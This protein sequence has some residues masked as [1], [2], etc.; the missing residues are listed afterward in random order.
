MKIKYAVISFFALLLILGVLSFMPHEMGMGDDTKIS[1]RDILPDAEVVKP[2]DVNKENIDV[3]PVAIDVNNKFPTSKEWAEYQKFHDYDVVLDG[4]SK[5]GYSAYSEVQ[6]IELANSGD[7]LAMKV[8][9]KRYNDMA[10][11][12]DASRAQFVNSETDNAI[13]F[14]VKEYT[15]KFN[16][17]VDKAILHGDRE[18]LT[19]MPNARPSLGLSS[20]NSEEAKEALLETMAVSE[21]WGMRGML[22]KKYE[23]LSSLLSIY[24]QRQGEKSI[25]LTP[26]INQQVKVRAQ[27]IYNSYEERRIALGLG[28][29]DNSLPQGKEQ[30]VQWWSAE[31][32]KRTEAE[33]GY[34]LP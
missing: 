4:E 25:K 26:E 9:A 2:K 27:E 8:L 19:D 18:L 11:E 21:F 5:S 24:H 15:K 33:L 30:E 13:R 28:P 22:D 17:Y 16:S 1:E 32:K 10:V 12:K 14:E 6:L 7:V 23:S 31:L 34:E 29:F 20:S 3:H